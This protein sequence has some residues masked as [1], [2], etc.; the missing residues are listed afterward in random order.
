[1]S[2]K[3]EKSLTH[4][5]IINTF[6]VLNNCHFTAWRMSLYTTVFL[7]QSGNFSPTVSLQLNH[8]SVYGAMSAA[9]GL[10]VT[11]NLMDPLGQVKSRPPSSEDPWMQYWLPL[12][13][14][15]SAHLHSPVQASPWEKHHTS[16]V[17]L[18]QGQSVRVERL[19]V[20][21]VAPPLTGSGGD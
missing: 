5:V 1:M 12:R 13:G 18:P 20:S 17:Y 6:I 7:V 9:S 8:T 19:R 15:S 2:N 10:G 16:Q 21:E 4:C 11:G 14:L 3:I